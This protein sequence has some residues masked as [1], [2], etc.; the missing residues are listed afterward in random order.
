MTDVV[1]S[2]NPEKH[3]YEAHIDGEL[4]GFAQY[5][6]SV[7]LITF[8]HTV[9][10]DKFEGRGVASTLVR[11]ALDDARADGSRRVLV[12]CP[13]IVRWIEKHPEYQDLLETPPAE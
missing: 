3:R 10:D 1:T 12:T 8:N 7:G 5:L 13:F 6:P 2:H 9:V 11:F 4:A